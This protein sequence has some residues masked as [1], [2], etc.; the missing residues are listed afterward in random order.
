M[1]INSV[2]SLVFLLVFGIYLTNVV[3]NIAHLDN[4]MVNATA[5]AMGVDD[6]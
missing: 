1:K 2:V 6:Q 3:I 5:T 4:P